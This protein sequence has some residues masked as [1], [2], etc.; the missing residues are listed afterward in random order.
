M[1]AETNSQRFRDMIKTHSFVRESSGAMAKVCMCHI[2]WKTRI[3]AVTHFLNVPLMSSF[4][5]LGL[6]LLF[7]FSPYVLCLI[8]LIRLSSLGRDCVVCFLSVSDLLPL[9]SPVRLSRALNPVMSPVLVS[10]VVTAPL[11]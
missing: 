2:L 9:L 6:L 8:C 10:Y 5:A 7:F 4:P 11:T 1:V 3:S